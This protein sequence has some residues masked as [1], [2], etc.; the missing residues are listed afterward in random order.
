MISQSRRLIL[1][2]VFFSLNIINVATN[3]AYA[4]PD[5]GAS[6]IQ[7]AVTEIINVSGY[8]YAEVNTGS[9][10]VWAAGP[11]T[12]LKTGDTV[13][14]LT[15]MPMKDFHSE[16]MNRDFPLIYFISSFITDT[17]K[18]AS[19]PKPLVQPKIQQMQDYL[20]G[21]A[22][23]EGGNNIAEV[24]AEKD[25]LKGEII[26][27][28]GKV[29]RFSA[30]ILGKNW[31]HIQDGSSLDDLTIT[32]DGT[33]DVGNVVIIKGKLELDKDFGHGYVFPL[34]VQNAKVTKE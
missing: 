24:H 17:D 34:I 19:H 5:M 26:Q 2:V 28:R 32:T 12:E 11:T 16:S 14:F 25:K 20:Q 29:T 15:K 18:Q 23:V 21:I 1:L 3:V 6:K 9:N 8:T 30:E 4:Q 31:L 10:K 33:V 7:G 22:K 13:A 27:V